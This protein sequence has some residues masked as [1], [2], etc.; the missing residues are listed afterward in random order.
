MGAPP[1]RLDALLTQPPGSTG[2]MGP[3]AS[4]KDLKDGWGRPLIYHQPGKQS[5]FDLGSYGY[6]AREGG[7]GLRGADIG[8][9]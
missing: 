7:E 9:P 5:A 2:W 4:E 8:T 1:E 6:D 3:Y